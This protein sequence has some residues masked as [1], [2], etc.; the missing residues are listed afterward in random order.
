[1]KKKEMIKKVINF[2][3]Y[4]ASWEKVYVEGNVF[5]RIKKAIKMV[6]N[7]EILVHRWIRSDK[8]QSQRIVKE[9]EKYEKEKRNNNKKNI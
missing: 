9:E 3:L 7:K 6:I 1:M 4:Q 8:K 5:E 2:Y